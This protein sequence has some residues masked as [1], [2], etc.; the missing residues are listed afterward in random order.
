MFLLTSGND[1]WVRLWGITLH[2][3][4]VSDATEPEEWLRIQRLH[5][6]KTNV[7]DV[8]S[9]SVLDAGDAAARVVICGVG[10]E[11]LRIEWDAGKLLC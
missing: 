7:A 5:K 2:D 8:S 9:M 3:A 1:E 10:M 11:V 6:V 4:P